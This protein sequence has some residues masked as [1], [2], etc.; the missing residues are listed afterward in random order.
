LFFF[1]SFPFCSSALVPADEGTDEQSHW[2]NV[3]PS[4]DK[5]LGLTD[6]LEFN[7]NDIADGLSRK[8]FVSFT[9][10]EMINLIKALF[11]DSPRRQSLIS[12]IAEISK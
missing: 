7:L 2:K 6:L 9:G 11:E 10:Q 5:F 1:L 12:S 4:W 8:R 3:C